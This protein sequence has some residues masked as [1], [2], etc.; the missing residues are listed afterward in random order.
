MPKMMHLAVYAD[1]A[2]RS[3][4]LPIPLTPMTRPRQR[5]NSG[6]KQITTLPE[7]RLA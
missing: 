2:M 7:G 1:G 5:K 4:R 3:S 6:K